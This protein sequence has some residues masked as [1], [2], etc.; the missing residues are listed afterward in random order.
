MNIVCRIFTDRILKTLIFQ[1]IIANEI[2]FKL[3]IPGVYCRGSIMPVQ[4]NFAPLG[5]CIFK[6]EK[7]NMPV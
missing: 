5:E 2:V 6:P 3:D 4:F 1:N 7:W